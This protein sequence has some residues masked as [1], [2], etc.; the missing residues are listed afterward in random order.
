MSMASDVALAYDLDDVISQLSVNGYAQIPLGPY[1]RR[2]RRMLA[3][4]P[5]T[6][7]ERRR[8]A[9]VTDEPNGDNEPTR[10]AWPSA[11]YPTV[12]SSLD[13]PWRSELHA[14]LDPTTALTSEIIG[15]IINKRYTKPVRIPKT[16]LQPVDDGRWFIRYYGRTTE[17]GDMR[18]L[19]YH[20]DRTT[21]T[22]LLQT[23]DALV[24]ER[25]GREPL[26]MQ[27]DHVVLF[28]GQYLHEM[29]RDESLFP[30]ASHGVWQK[31]AVGAR[32]SLVMRPIGPA[33]FRQMCAQEEDIALELDG[34]DGLELGREL[35]G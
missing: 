11:S 34:A 3:K 31:D 10:R 2:A 4:V 21:I 32:M 5:L 1:A 29:V 13:E 33:R 25:Q 8:L 35:T 30:P 9:Q 20:V 27:P 22:A 23:D 24:V 6:R 19:E 12:G 18:R 17:S 26:R 14:F 16:R 15:T 7:S 28:V